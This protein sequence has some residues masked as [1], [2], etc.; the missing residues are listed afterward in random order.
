MQNTKQLAKLLQ[1]QE[2]LA[3]KIRDIQRGNDTRYKILIG[4]AILEAEKAGELPK[5]WSG[6]L[7]AKY[8]KRPT[9]RKFLELPELNKSESNASTDATTNG[10]QQQYQQ[11]Y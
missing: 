8:I 1:Q 2:Q 11:S 3:K 5:G 9:D 4:V 6:K 10:H 7:L